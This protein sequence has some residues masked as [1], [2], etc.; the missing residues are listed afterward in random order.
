[1]IYSSEE[2]EVDL[3]FVAILETDGY[4]HR[5]GVQSQ[6]LSQLGRD[7]TRRRTQSVALIGETD[8]RHMISSHLEV[9]GDGLGLNTAHRAQDQHGSV[10]HPEG[11]LD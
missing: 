5:G 10:K 4:M 11:P 9:H 6:F 2:V 3:T 1:M 7:L 8:P